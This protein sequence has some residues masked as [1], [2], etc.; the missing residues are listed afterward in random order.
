MDIDPDGRLWVVEMRGFMPNFEGTGEDAPVGQV[1]VL[2]DTDDDGRAD[3]AHRVPRR[4]GPAADGEGARSRRARDRPAAADP[5]PRHRRRSESRHPR[6]AAH[7]RRGQGRQPGAQPEQPAVGP[8]QLALHLGAHRRLPLDAHRTGDRK[9][10]LARA[11]GHLDRRH[12]PC[13]PQLERRSAA[14][15]LPARA[16]PRAQPGRGPHARRLRAGDRGP[17]GVGGAADARRSI[18]AIATACC[19]RTARSRS[20]R[21]PARRPSIAAIACLPTSAA[22]CS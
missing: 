1:V 5:R 8:R 20:S 11:V 9:D 12:R 17:G 21:R 16:R 18:A 15:R 7:R 4:P 3:R 14:R 10:A 2:E 13:L 19:G 6:G 22:M